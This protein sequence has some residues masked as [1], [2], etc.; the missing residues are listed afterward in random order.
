MKSEKCITEEWLE[1]VVL[2]LNFCPFFGKGPVGV[3]GPTLVKMTSV[4]AKSI[5]AS[6]DYLKE[7]GLCVTGLYHGFHLYPQTKLKFENFYQLSCSIQN[8]LDKLSIAVEVV[9]FHPDFSFEGEVDRGH[10]VNRSPYPSLHLIGTKLMN[11]A[12]EGQNH[13]FGEKLSLTNR[14]KLNQMSEN[15]FSQ[16]VLKYSQGFWSN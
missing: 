11:K 3:K 12:T 6:L 4:D 9:C 8:R 5:R 2:D 15:E 13:D 16:R 1:R 7:D 14:D 10:Y